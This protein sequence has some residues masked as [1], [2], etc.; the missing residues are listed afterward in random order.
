MSPKGLLGSFE[1]ALG[2]GDLGSEPA[3][4]LAEQVDGDGA[5]VV[6]VKELLAL[7]GELGEA[8]ALAGGFLLPLLAHAG[9]GLIELHSDELSLRP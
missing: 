9:E 8:A 1:V 5:R 3:L 2:L 7:G 4:L 6:G